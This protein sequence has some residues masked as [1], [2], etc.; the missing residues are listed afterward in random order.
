MSSENVSHIKDDINSERDYPKPNLVN[1]KKGN[2]ND[3]N[4]TPNEMINKMERENFPPADTDKM[5]DLLGNKKKTK[6]NVE[7]FQ[8]KEH[9]ENADHNTTHDTHQ[10]SAPHQYSASHYQSRDEATIQT[11]AQEETEEDIMLK[12]LDMMRKLGELHKCGIKLSQNYNMRSDYKTMKYEYELHKG[13]RDKHNTIG[14]L[15]KIIAGGCYFLERGNDKFNPFNF[16]LN[17]WAEVVDSDIQQNKYYDV[18]GELYEKYFKVGKPMSPEVK[19]IGMIALSALSFHLAHTMVNNQPSAQT[20]LNNNPELTQ[21]LRQQASER[22]KKQNEQYHQTMNEK[23]E[24][25]HKIVR[26]KL[27][28]INMLKGQE[29]EYLKEQQLQQKKNEVQ[30]LQNQLNILRSDSR[31]MYTQ[32]QDINNQRTMK[33]PPSHLI[34]RLLPQKNI[35]YASPAYHAA[36]SI[37]QQQMMNMQENRQLRNNIVINDTLS[38]DGV[39]EA[40]INPNIEAILSGMSKDRNSSNDDSQSEVKS[41]KRKRGRR[42]KIKINTL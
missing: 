18:L 34:S 42:K 10:Y 26:K 21:K 14:W 28:D 6:Q 36:E 7:F 2:E 24:Q 4:L 31:S 8:K 1:N 9:S 22:I 37:R 40:G 12:K 41:S 30:E 17:G 11:T 25:E 15:G 38:H 35:N 20:I 33:G 5:F 23:V 19:L 3:E 16:E 39:S 27:D 13:I 32:S 29:E